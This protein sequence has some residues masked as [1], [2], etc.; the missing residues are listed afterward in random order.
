M[1]KVTGPMISLD[2]R[3]SIGNSVNFSIR[4]GVN[5]TRQH[6][7]PGNPQTAAQSANREVFHDGVSK[8]RFCADL[9][10]ELYKTQWI[11][12]AMGTSESGYN[13]FMRYYLSANYDKIT[14]TKVSPQQIPL[15]Q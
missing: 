2:A 8:W 9:I 5:Y 10:P 11:Y 15:P 4:R 14:K 13:R 6:I 1:T 7:I 3:G 12:Y